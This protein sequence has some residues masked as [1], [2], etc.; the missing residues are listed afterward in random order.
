MRTYELVFIADPRTA[1][2][3]VVAMTEEYKQ[4]IVAGG[5]EITQEEQWGRRKLAYPI[6][7]LNEGKYVVL[8]ISSAT[9][10]TALPDVEHRLQQNERILRFLTVRTDLDLKRAEGRKRPPRRQAGF[11]EARPT[12]E[13][14]DEPE[15]AGK[16]V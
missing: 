13:V 16:E 9:G 15:G 7:K 6:N 10:K 4:M 5:S 1:D 8:Y 14:A 12:D 2:E 11:D 3:D